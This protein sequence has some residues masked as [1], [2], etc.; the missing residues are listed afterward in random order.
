[1]LTLHL[2]V[3][4]LVNDFVAIVVRT[5]ALILL[6]CKISLVY[7]FS[8]S[9]YIVN[10]NYYIFTKITK[11]NNDWFSQTFLDDDA[12]ARE[13]KSLLFKYLILPTAPFYGYRQI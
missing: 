9:A 1:M 11:H 2:F 8:F 5:A 13:C 6:L 12:L 10:S 7:Y 4:F 3:S